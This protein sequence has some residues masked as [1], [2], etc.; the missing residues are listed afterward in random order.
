MN[1]FC[2][3]DWTWTVEQFLGKTKTRSS[4]E[5][6][7][8]NF[9]WCSLECDKT[10]AIEYFPELAC[11]WHW[12]LSECLKLGSFPVDHENFGWRKFLWCITKRQATEL[13]GLWFS[14]RVCCQLQR[15]DDSRMQR[16]QN[17]E[18]GSFL[19]MHA[20]TCAGDVCVWRGVGAHRKCQA[21]RITVTR[22]RWILSLR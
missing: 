4:K 7:G 5:M 15:D 2:L 12:L 1:F 17:C 8:A 6:Q 20:G 16:K 21:N 22:E 3:C 13:E 18:I 9:S 14:F 11:I 10:Y 19:D